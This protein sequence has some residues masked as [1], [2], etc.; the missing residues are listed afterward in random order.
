MSGVRVLFLLVLLCPVV[1]CSGETKGAQKLAVNS[2][3]PAGDVGTQADIVRFADSLV[4]EFL[5]LEAAGNYW[6]ATEMIHGCPDDRY[7]SSDEVHPTASASIVKSYLR[8]DTVDVSVEYLELGYVHEK[9]D[10][11]V[12][13]SKTLHFDTTV[14]YVGLDS[15]GDLSILCGWHPADH[16]GVQATTTH[17]LSKFNE[18]S[19]KEW[20]EA[21]DS[22]AKLNHGR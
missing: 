22:A 2:D 20:S 17:L 3:E 14:F 8:N 9:G 7:V 19:Q 12:W 10:G 11:D 5:S 16:W 15:S 4:A 1:T 21:V 18:E 13:F 6:S